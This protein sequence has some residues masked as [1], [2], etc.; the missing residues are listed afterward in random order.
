LS[1]GLEHLRELLDFLSGARLVPS[2]S[3]R[4]GGLRCWTGRG[5]VVAGY[6]FDVT[7]SFVLPSAIAAAVFAAATMLA[8]SLSRRSS[9]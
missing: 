6:G 1:K 9:G 2:E 5:P 8:L 7:G 4:D 3:E